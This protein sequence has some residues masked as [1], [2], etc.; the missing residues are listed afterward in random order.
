VLLLLGAKPV[1]TY[2]SARQQQQC[3]VRG[4]DGNI[5][6]QQQP[7]RCLNAQPNGGI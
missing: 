5:M 3:W 4:I 2:K 7:Q 1:L 6:Q